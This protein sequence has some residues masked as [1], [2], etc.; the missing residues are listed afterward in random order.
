MGPRGPVGGLVHGNGVRAGAQDRGGARETPM[1]PLLPG[2]LEG[3]PQDDA[4]RGFTRLG[5]SP[6]PRPRLHLLW[7]LGSFQKAFTGTPSNPYELE[8]R[9]QGP[10]TKTLD[11]KGRA[12]SLAAGGG[13]RRPSPA[14]LAQELGGQSPCPGRG[15][16]RCQPRESETDGAGPRLTRRLG[17]PPAA[18]VS[19]VPVARQ[20]GRRGGQSQNSEFLQP[21]TSV[22]LSRSLDGQG[23][24]RPT[25]R[26]PG[27]LRV[28]PPCGTPAWLLGPPRPPPSRRRGLTP[29]LR[30][31]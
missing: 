17:A 11:S 28:R 29:L 24:G 6:P 15:G 19:G 4:S 27:G 12:H 23:L 5:P 26:P 9:P 25:C 16:D 18:P 30:L 1:R 21:V 2:A 10:Q 3:R 14:R 20:R 13:R 8:V 22:R 7:V 31:C